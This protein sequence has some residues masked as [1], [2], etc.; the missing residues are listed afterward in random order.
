MIAL[1][2]ISYTH[3][4]DVNFIEINAG[5]PNAV[6]CIFDEFTGKFVHFAS[7]FRCLQTFSCRSRHDGNLLLDEVKLFFFLNVFKG[8][9][10][11]IKVP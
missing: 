7:A 5:E 10:V 8:F 2:L 3:N 6:N 11:T 9:K 4:R 1:T